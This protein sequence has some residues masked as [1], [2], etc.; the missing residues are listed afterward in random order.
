MT[1]TT[2]GE[3][4]GLDAHLDA[5]LANYDDNLDRIP[6]QPEAAPPQAAPAAEKSDQPPQQALDESGRAHG[7]DGKFVTK[8]PA[9]P[10]HSQPEQAKAEA[11]PATAPAADVPAP[12]E[13]VEPHPMWSPELKGQFAKWPL[14]AQKAFRATYDQT[15]SSHTRKTQEL[16][17]IRKAIEPTYSEVQRQQPFLQAIGYT[18][19]RFL[20]ESAAVAQNLMSG[21]PQSQG[22]G[23]AYLMNM[24]RVPPEAV[25]QALG[26]P[27]NPGETVQVNPAIQQL[28]Q[29]QMQMAQQLQS[30][31]KEYRDWQY[32]TAV[33]QFDEEGARTDQNG[34]R[35]YP[36]WDRVKDT[37]INL[38]ANGPSDI[39]WDKA[40]RKAVRMDDE[41][42]EATFESERNRVIESEAQRRQ[43]AVDKARKASPVVTTP[44][45][46]GGGQ[47]LR[48]LDAH[49][50]A[51]MAKHM[52]D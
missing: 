39:T 47:E 7:A 13:S 25:L 28:H 36:H 6:E 23:I 19:D 42:F 48:G 3:A 1:D 32:N 29:S 18:P 40:Y 30:F 2:Q 21:N 22:Q 38:V 8:A 34:N 20:R 51:A 37:M 4:K 5:A 49:L 41:L 44:S 17:E 9:K 31:Q 16:S 50:R 43:A 45:A 24:Y 12:Q 27:L 35:L 15:E 26:V 10:K 52:P 46:P 11:K 33:Q 14:E